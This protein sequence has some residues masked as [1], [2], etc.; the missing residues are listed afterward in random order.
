MGSSGSPALQAA[1]QCSSIASS[2]SLSLAVRPVCALDPPLDRRED[3]LEQAR[4]V[5]GGREEEVDR[6]ARDRGVRT[7]LHFLGE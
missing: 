5:G 1:K 4:D 6:L 2:A 3:G 7:R